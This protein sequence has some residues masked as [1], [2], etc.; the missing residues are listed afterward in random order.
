MKIIKK[1]PFDFGNR[2]VASCHRCKKIFIIFPTFREIVQTIGIVTCILE[3]SKGICYLFIGG[4]HDGSQK[5][6]VFRNILVCFLSCEN[7]FFRKIVDTFFEGAMEKMGPV[8]KLIFVH[9]STAGVNYLV[10]RIISH[11]QTCIRFF[12][13]IQKKPGQVLVC[14]IK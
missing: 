7:A 8:R 13:L 12:C 9:N 6:V 14:L 4:S 11:E 5:P 3:N 2:A 1:Q 10:G